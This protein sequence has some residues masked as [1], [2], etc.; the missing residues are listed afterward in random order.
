MASMAASTIIPILGFFAS[1]CRN[2]QRASGGTKK[3]FSARYSSLS[4]GSAP[5]YSPSPFFSFSYRPSKASDMYLRKMSPKTTCLYSAA[6]I[7][8]L[9]LSAAFQSC[10]SS[11]SSCQ[12]SFF[13]A[14]VHSI[15][16]QLLRTGNQTSRKS[17]CFLVLLISGI[18]VTLNFSFLS[19]ANVN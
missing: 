16:E 1:A 3:T 9:S 14:M 11:G 7:F 17:C 13:F 12:L 19:E 2:D 18:K 10:F 4:S 5:A 8:F 15:M 6:S